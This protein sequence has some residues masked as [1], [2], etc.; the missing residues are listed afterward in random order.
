MKTTRGD[1]NW[2]SAA[3]NAFKQAKELLATATLLNHPAPDAPTCIMTD[4]SDVV[5]GAVLQQFID[6]IWKPFSYFFRKL[7][8]AE[9]RYSTYDRDLLAIYLSVRHFRHFIEGCVFHVVMDHKPLTYSLATNSNRYSPCQIRHLDFI[10]QF[11]RDIRHINGCDNSVADALSRIDVSSL[12]QASPQIDFNALAAAQQDTELQTLRRSSTSLTF[13]DVSI[14]GVELSLICDFSTGQSCL[15]L[16]I[17]FRFPVFELL[18]GL[19]HPGIRAS[20]RLITFTYIWPS[21]KVG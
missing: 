13:D 18:H 1:F 14:P 3:D 11:T 4:A 6:G 12:Q 8:T 17:S 10:F 15:Y 9:S 21:M 2:S 5:V 16:P 19:S 7:N 20:Q